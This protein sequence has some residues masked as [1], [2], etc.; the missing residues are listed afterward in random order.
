[1]QRN[2]RRAESRPSRPCGGCRAWEGTVGRIRTHLDHR[3]HYH[4]RSSIRRTL[5]VIGSIRP[6][7]LAGTEPIRKNR[8]RSNPRVTA[9]FSRRS[10][11]N[12]R[13]TGMRRWASARSRRGRTWDRQWWTAQSCVSTGALWRAKTVRCNPC[14]CRGDFGAMPSSVAAVV[15]STLTSHPEVVAMLFRCSHRGPI[16]VRR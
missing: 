14:A 9:S 2:R 10:P 1:M 6:L 12:R 3:L 16:S 11:C 4:E 8:R 13:R 5:S 15:N 7:G